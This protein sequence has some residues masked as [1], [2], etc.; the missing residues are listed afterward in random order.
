[1][2][3]G[4]K[5]D[6]QANY[7][8]FIN[9]EVKNAPHQGFSV[10]GTGHEFINCD[11]H[12]NGISDFAH[13]FYYGGDT[14]LIEGCTI[15]NNAGWGMTLYS[16][17]NPGVVHDNVIRN[18]RIY[19]NAAVGA[20]GPG[21]HLGGGANNQAYNNV[22]YGNN[23][24]IQVA[25]GGTIDTLIYNNTIFDNNAGTNNA[26]GISIDATYSTATDT[27]I[28]NNI[29]YSHNRGVIVETGSPTGTVTSNNLTT[30]PLFV[31]SAQLDFHLGESSTAI[32]AGELVIGAPD[33][34]DDFDGNL[35]YQG[36]GYDIGAYE[37]TGL[38]IDNVPPAAPIDV[39]IASN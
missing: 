34:F 32:D 16:Q 11:V 19:D 21:I 31:N 7:I 38:P 35:R 39:T 6:T 18:N 37:F 3:G 25:Y 9:C 12:D 2:G 27:I 15:H 4:L 24:G 14:G 26:A 13:G 30:D 10:A 17:G 5:V 20:R 8:R 1:M 29:I 33:D 23:G 28:K 22:I 36:S